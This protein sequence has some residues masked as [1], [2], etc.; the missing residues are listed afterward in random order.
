[1][2]AFITSLRHPRNSADYARVEELLQETLRSVTNQTSDDFVVIVVGNRAPS[3]AL[4]DR[5]HFVEVDFRA[6]APASERIRRS[7][8]IR[9]KG[10][11]IGVG[12]IA[13]RD[14]S[15]DYV[16][17]FDADDFVHRGLAEF[18][19][20]NPGRD[21]WVIDEGWMYSRRRSAVQTQSTFNRVC[22]TCFIIPFD[23]YDVPADLDVSATRGQVREAYGERLSKIIGAHKHAVEWHEARGRY[24]ESLPFRGAVYHVDN[25]E[26][27]SSNVM[28]GRAKPL[29]AAL[30]AEFGIAA[31][32]GRVM[33]WWA[34]YLSVPFSRVTSPF[35]SA[36]QAMKRIIRSGIRAG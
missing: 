17:I 12:L 5:V 22:G 6:P 20:Q 8:F 24:L 21:G 11:K 16:M 31:Q 13:A 1:M 4:P 36:M 27:H 18:V 25:G 23:A 2:I 33:T 28:T 35:T 3:F 30:A 7:P 26:N 10:T 15:P 34:C 14:F 29:D 19:G 9:D 32:R